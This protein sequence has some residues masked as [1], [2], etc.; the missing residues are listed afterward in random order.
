[1]PSAQPDSPNDCFDFG[2]DV[3]EFGAARGFD[4]QSAGETAARLVR[5]GCH[6]CLNMPSLQPKINIEASHRR[7][8]C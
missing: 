7:A 8:D 5:L 2:G 4:E 3:F 6:H 1:M